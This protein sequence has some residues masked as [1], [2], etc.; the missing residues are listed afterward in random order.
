MV[1]SKDQILQAAKEFDDAIETRDVNHIL[2]FFSD[3]CKILLFGVTLQ[4][5]LGARRWLE[6]MFQH[7][8]EIR[9]EP[10]TIMVEGNIFFE[11]FIVH[12]KLED[13]T[14]LQSHQAEVLVYENL[15]VKELR[16]YF[17]RLDFAQAVA[18]GFISKAIV[19]RLVK[20]SLEGLV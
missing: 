18:K 12:A 19:N 2:S 16:L 11:E 1:H 9:F 8:K 15:L 20:K 4:G 6:W 13:G 5:K 10:I 3:Q 14:R 7:L 17:D